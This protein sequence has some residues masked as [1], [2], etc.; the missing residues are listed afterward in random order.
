MLASAYCIIILK[1]IQHFGDSVLNPNKKEKEFDDIN[2]PENTS[3]LSP[4]HYGVSAHDHQGGNP[5]SSPNISRS[6]STNAFQQDYM[7]TKIS[8]TSSCTQVLLL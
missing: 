5:S 7:A 6:G 2:P 4:Q 3:G 1:G 8:E